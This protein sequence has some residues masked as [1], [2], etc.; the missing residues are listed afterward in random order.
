MAGKQTIE[1]LEFTNFR[2]A[3]KPVTF[4]F[5]PNQPIVL[6]F[7]ENGSG[8]S[9]IADALDFLCNSDFGSLRLRSGTTP[10]TH[11]VAAE[12]KASDLQWR[13]FMGA[14]H[15]G[16]RCKVASPLPRLPNHHALLCCAA[17]TSRASWKPRIAN[18]I[19]A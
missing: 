4:Q 17:P 2:G 9:T 13:W 12:G 14:I 16:Q 8:K 18:A 15:G 6:I 3:T 19:R 11:I 1:R 10:R 7:G 5:R